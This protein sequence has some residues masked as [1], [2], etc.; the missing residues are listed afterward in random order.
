MRRERR[1]GLPRGPNG[2]R[3]AGARAARP[4][5]KWRR[6]PGDTAGTASRRS[7]VMGTRR[8]GVEQEDGVT[9]AVHSPYD[10]RAP[11]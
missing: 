9:R 2:P 7:D 11:L 4:T 6:A 5:G 3:V 10:S 1:T 8:T